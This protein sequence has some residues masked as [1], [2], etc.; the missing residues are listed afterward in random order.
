MHPIQAL[1]GLKSCEM[2]LDVVVLRVVMS[3]LKGRLSRTLRT[4]WSSQTDWSPRV[5]AS[6]PRVLLPTTTTTTTFTPRA[7]LAQALASVT[8]T[9]NCYNQETPGNVLL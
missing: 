1:N 4:L 6:P 7:R 8:L 3:A 2:C 5:V 9:S